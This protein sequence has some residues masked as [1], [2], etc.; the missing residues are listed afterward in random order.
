MPIAQLLCLTF[1]YSLSNTVLAPS[2]E[3]WK[4]VAEYLIYFFP[5]KCFDENCNLS[6][7]YIKSKLPLLN[8]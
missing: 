7:T 1:F 2:Y 3:S 5:V 8:I 6:I 4:Y